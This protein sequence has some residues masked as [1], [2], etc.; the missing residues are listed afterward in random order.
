M[1]MITAARSPSGSLRAARPGGESADLWLDHHDF[2]DTY[3]LL[4]DPGIGTTLHYGV[5]LL[6]NVQ[7][8]NGQVVQVGKYITDPRC[9]YCPAYPDLPFDYD[10]IQ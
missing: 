10:C 8:V 6:D 9:F 3:Y 7:L 2:N 4:K 5:A 1:R